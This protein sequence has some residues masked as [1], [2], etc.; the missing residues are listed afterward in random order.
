[1][2]TYNWSSELLTILKAAQTSN[3]PFKVASFFPANSILPSGNEDFLLRYPDLEI[4]TQRSNRTEFV[5]SVREKDYKTLEKMRMPLIDYYNQSMKEKD[6]FKYNKNYEDLLPHAFIDLF[7]ERLNRQD[8]E[9]VTLDSYWPD[10]Y[11][12]F[13]YGLKNHETDPHYDW[14]PFNNI[15]IQIY[16]SKEVILFSPETFSKLPLIYN[17]V[18]FS[19]D[20]ILHYAELEN[21]PYKRVVIHSG[22]G[23]FIPHYCIHAV[24]Y[25][26]DSSSASLRLLPKKRLTSLHQTLPANAALAQILFQKREFEIDASLKNYDDYIDLYQKIL[27]QAK[28]DMDSILFE[29]KLFNE[30]RG[31][32]FILAD[33]SRKQELV[34]RGAAHFSVI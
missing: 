5:R 1:M 14:T 7:K 27:P 19:Y 4:S 30:K 2:I 24:K 22:E 9:Q 10:Y 28:M 3:E 26:S 34:K 12:R 11:Y 13:F 23:L 17:Q 29:K 16:G 33:K 20:E 6:F 15:L 32:D 25:L 8:L 18:D 31:F 21:I